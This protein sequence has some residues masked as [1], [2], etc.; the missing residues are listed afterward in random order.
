VGA[1]VGGVAKALTANTQANAPP[2]FFI[3]AARRRW[4]P[5]ESRSDAIRAEVNASIDWKR[6]LFSIPGY[7]NVNYVANNV[8]GCSRR[9][10]DR[11]GLSSRELGQC[12]I[13]FSE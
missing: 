3:A 2:E 11:G 9:T 6:F 1:I 4:P 8:I 13:H 10:R 5:S 7:R 12:R